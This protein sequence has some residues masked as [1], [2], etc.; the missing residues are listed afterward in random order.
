MVSRA[1]S[2]NK[3]FWYKLWNF[4][5]FDIHLEICSKTKTSMGAQQWKNAEDSLFSLGKGNMESV[6]S[7]VRYHHTR[8]DS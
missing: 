8:A 2:S 6:D 7:I 5:C 1:L 3:T 4:E